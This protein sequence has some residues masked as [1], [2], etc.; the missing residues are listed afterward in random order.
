MQY[1]SKCHVFWRTC[2][3]SRYCQRGSRMPKIIEQI[4]NRKRP[5]RIFTHALHPTT[6]IEKIRAVGFSP[7]GICPQLFDRI[8]QN[9][10]FG[11]VK[12]ILLGVFNSFLHCNRH[13]AC[14]LPTLCPKTLHH[15]LRVGM[16]DV[17]DRLCDKRTQWDKT[18]RERD[19]ISRHSQRLWG[20]TRQPKSP[21]VHI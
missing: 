20:F 17:L 6:E 18:K 19:K 1:F 5:N 21:H 12:C 8:C 9:L 13:S 10:W 14:S 2:F 3:W 11:Q 16:T 7:D 4:V 15:I